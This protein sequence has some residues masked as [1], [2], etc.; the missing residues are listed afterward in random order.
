MALFLIVSGC[1]LQEKA[2]QQTGKIPKSDLLSIEPNGVYYEIFVRSFADSN[3]DGIGDLK[4]ATEK[5][6]YLADLGIEGIW[7]MPVHPSP[8]YHGYDVTDYKEINPDYGSLEDMKDFVEKAHSKGIKVIIDL[9]VNH[10]SKEHPWFQKAL[11]GDPAFRDYYVWAD[12]N[13]NTMALGEW[14][15]QV[16]HG[17][18]EDKYE[19]I[20]WEGMPDLNFE[21]PKVRKEMIQIGEFWLKDIGVDGFRLDAAKHIFS[22]TSSDDP[23]S[24]NHQWWKEFR[25]EMEKVQSDVILVGEVWDTATVVAPYLNEGLT[26]AFNFDLSEKI[27]ATVKSESDSGIVTTLS[28]IR[29]FFNK[30]SNGKFVDSTFIT[31]HDMPRVMTELNGN[32]DQAKMAASLLFTLPGNPFIYYGEETGMEGPKPDEEIRE[33]FIWGM[34]KDT[35]E[36]TKWQRIKHNQNFEEKSVE[37][38]LKD[39]NSLLNH[40]RNMIYLRRS[41]EILISGEIE[42]TLTKQQGMVTFKRT[43]KDKSLMVIHNVS[44]K[45]ISFSLNEKESDFKN[46]IFTS[47]KDVEVKEDG[48]KVSI[49]MP[50]YSTLILN[51]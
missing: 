1:S 17:L 40:Y 30:E 21:N 6:D 24:N 50:S 19:G 32:Q 39:E 12:G 28:R 9:V 33:P 23:E 14:N 16:W 51:K 45:P 2:K 31:N 42:S 47:K 5:L 8:S 4:G 22:P 13:T 20:F 49:D 46:I 27:L 34:D 25:T 3:S 38:Q 43:L 36:Q 41:N 29:E 26:S 10:T 18:G 35:P 44:S 15:Q 11:K 7:L 48:D 37:S